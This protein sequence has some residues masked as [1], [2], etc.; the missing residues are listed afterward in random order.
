MISNIVFNYNKKTYSTAS[1]FYNI[2][3]SPN[4]PTNIRNLCMTHTQF[5]QFYVI[6][7]IKILLIK[8]CNEIP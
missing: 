8:K 3:G 4:V 7:F 6:I 5:M 1:N 2:E